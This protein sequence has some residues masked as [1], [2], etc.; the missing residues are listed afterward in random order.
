[1][2]GC[3]GLVLGGTVIMSGLGD[4][5]PVVSCRSV[6]GGPCGAHGGAVVTVEADAGGVERRLL[7]GQLV[8]PGC[9]GVLAGWGH[10][11]RR[12]ARGPDGLVWMRP[13]RSRCIGCGATHVLQGSSNF[14]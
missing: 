5:P 7:A 10:A 4:G 1:M 9:S 14:F 8:C 2:L 6:P 13:R 3:L 11:R 12:A